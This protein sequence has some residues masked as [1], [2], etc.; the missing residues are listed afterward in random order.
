MSSPEQSDRR[1]RKGRCAAAAAALVL[2]VTPGPAARGQCE[3]VALLPLD[4]TAADTFG[5]SVAV[6]A[7]GTRII[8]GAGTAFHAVAGAGAGAGRPCRPARVRSR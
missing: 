3:L 4:G 2:A 5:A 1:R 6:S 8:V 7:D